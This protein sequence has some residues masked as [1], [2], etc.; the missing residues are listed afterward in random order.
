M[1]AKLPKG[2]RWLVEGELLIDGDQREASP[3]PGFHPTFFVGSTVISNFTYIRRIQP[4]RT[5]RKK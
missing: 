2:W 4:T 5:A 1:S 3:N